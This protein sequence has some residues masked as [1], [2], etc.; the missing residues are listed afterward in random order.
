[1]RLLR[2]FATTTCLLLTAALSASA[3][4]LVYTLENGRQP[5][6]CS[7]GGCHS[8]TIHLI[9][10][11]TSHEFSTIA[12]GSQNDRGTSLRLS[13]D[14]TQLFMT[15]VQHSTPT[16]QGTLWIVDAVNGVL[17]GS[18]AVG[19]GAA[20]VA[21]LPDN[22]RAYVVNRNS[23]S[24]SV[25]DLTTVTVVKT[26][27]VQTGPSRIAVGPTGNAV[28]VVN[29]GA[30]TVS[31]ISTAADSVE[32]TITVG[33]GPAG[34]DI[35][36]DGSRI[37]VANSGSQTVT[38][39]DA[40]LDSVL[41]S[42]PAGSTTAPPVDVSSPSPSRVF[43]TISDSTGSGS[44]VQLLNAQDGTVLG[45]TAILAGGR[46]ARNASGTPAYVIETGVTS[47]GALKLVATDSTSTTLIAPGAWAAAAVLTDPC[48]FESFASPRVFGP[49]GG[50][51][52]LTIAAPAGC[53]W[54]LDTSRA[55]GVTFQGTL[56]GTGPATR[57]YSIAAADAPKF[58][59]PA[60]NRQTLTLE[61]TIPRMNVE[62][63]TTGSA[64]LQEPFTVSGWAVDQNVGPVTFIFRSRGI[65]FLHVWAYPV[66]GASPIF[67]G[68]PDLGFLR[69]DVAALYGG[70][71][72]GFRLT[73]TNL[74]TG[75]YTLVVYAHSEISN[76]FVIAQ[77]VNVTVIAAQPTVVIDT[78]GNDVRV[79][80][81]FPIAGWAVDPAATTG[82]GIDFVHVWAYPSTGAAP[83]FVGAPPYGTQRTDVGAF[84]GS[85]FAASGYSMLGSLPPGRYTL[86]VF[87]HSTVSGQFI[88]Q[89]RAIVV[90][91]SDPFMV[92]DAPVGGTLTSP[93]DVIGWALDR[94]VTNGNSTD[95]IHVWAYPTNG[96]API[97]VGAADRMRRPDVAAIFG[98]TQVNAGFTLR[99][100]LPPGT[101]DLVVFARSVLTQTFNNAR[102][103][104]I[105][106][107]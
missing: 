12:V 100:T 22:S 25:V 17:L 75:S 47:G 14:G 71:L 85:Q 96:G 55:A 31:K 87:A 64:T 59:I 98:A 41:R 107:Q 57:T 83:V 38:V 3:Q 77:P 68:K 44:A 99:G 32:T 104:R 8:P 7:A 61:Q 2:L 5:F 60:V 103:V 76:T 65:D 82:T 42:L 90:P 39:I 40:N 101:Y 9:N 36:P 52:T 19:N 94:G 89:T 34:I 74:P 93:F 56:S 81:P 27:A 97:F 46:L 23:D 92:I 95:A 62:A 69:N 37:V 51:G 21:V 29:S 15:S 67:V 80:R 84:F 54:T 24:V 53:S 13:S 6:I 73:V 79:G 10:A 48:A 78:P 50:S 30:N 88:P 105:T 33:V 16:G 43:V 66:S 1:M 28:Y 63:P 49:A 11:A 26:V 72:S 18:V 70:L 86:V 35:S 91:E 106:V 45:S 4:T 58:A 102:V 20:D